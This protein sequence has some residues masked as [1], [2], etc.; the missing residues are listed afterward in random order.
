M[1]GSQGYQDTLSCVSALSKELG[2]SDED[3]LVLSTGV[4][5]QR[6]KMDE[7]LAGVPELVNKLGKKPEDAL[8]AAVAM[9]TTG[10]YR[11]ELL[12]F[13]FSANLQGYQ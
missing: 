4:I 7:L 2:I 6:I 13:D 9:T 8:K 1:T 10:W 3:V 11:R 12:K 5:G